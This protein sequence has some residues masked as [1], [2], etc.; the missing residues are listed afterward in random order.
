[1]HTVVVDCSSIS[2]IDTSA[3]RLLQRV[4]AKYQKEVGIADVDSSPLPRVVSTALL[5]V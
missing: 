5:R 2:T 4:V 1:M 3:V